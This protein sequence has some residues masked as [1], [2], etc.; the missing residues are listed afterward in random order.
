[1][2]KNKVIKPVGFNVT[3]EKD[4]ALLE[5]VKNANFSGYVKELIFSDLQKRNQTLRIVQKSEN[6]GI[7]YV[8]PT[9]NTTSPPKDCVT[10]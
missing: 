3:N 9:G 1:M 6:G 8:L 5:H 10:L 7:K 4:V 2:S